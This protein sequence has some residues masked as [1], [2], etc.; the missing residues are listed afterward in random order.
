MRKK[1]LVAVILAIA[2]MASLIVPAQ[3][4]AG[5][6][7]SVPPMPNIT[8]Y[9][10][11]GW[12]AT[13]WRMET[14]LQ[15]G[16]VMYSYD[17]DPSRVN[18]GYSGYSDYQ[19]GIAPDA[20]Q[21]TSMPDQFKGAD[22]FITRPTGLNK[23]YFH[24]EQA[25]TVYAAI[26]DSYTTNPS[27]F[28]GWNN[29]NY[30]MKIK[31]GTTYHVVSKNFNG[32]QDINLGTG[33]QDGGKKNVF[34]VILPQNGQTVYNATQTGNPL[35]AEGTKPA[36][37]AADEAYQYYLNDV[38][39]LYSGTAVPAGYEGKN[40]SLTTGTAGTKTIAD[41]QNMA[42]NMTFIP[43]DTS[44][45]GSV[46]DGSDQT[47][48][49][50][51]RGYSTSPTLATPNIMTID[52]GGQAK[53][54]KIVLKCMNKSSWADRTQNIKLEYS[55]DGV[56]YKTLVAAKDYVFTMTK[57]NV[58]DPI[59]FNQVTARFVRATI[60]TNT[61]Q[62]AGQIAE[63]EIYGPAQTYELE[64]KLID[65]G[66]TVTEHYI[67]VTKADKF[68]YETAEFTKSFSQDISGKVIFEGKVMSSETNQYMEIPVMTDA[69]GKEAV[70]L[71]FDED[72]LMKAASAD[73]VKEIAP[74]TANTWYT[75]K[76]LVD[77]DADE[78]E[79]WVD[80]IRKAQ[81]ISFV[82]NI[83]S[84]AKLRFAVGIEAEGTLYVDNLRLY[85]N[86]EIYVVQDEF[87]EANTGSTYTTGWSYTGSATIANVPFATDKSIYMNGTGNTA[88]RSF[89]PISGDVTVE[90]KVKP[91]TENWVTMPMVTD[92]S[93]KVAAKVAFYQNSLYISNGDN[94]VYVCDQEIPNNYYLA[95]NWFTIKLIM[96]TYTNR[97]DF[98]VDGAPR[99]SGASFVE[100]V[101]SVSRVVFKNEQNSQMYIDNVTVYDSASLARG[102]Y[103]Q[104]NVFNVRDFGAKGDGVT[105]DTAAVDAAILAAAGTG[106]TVLFENGT[107]YVGQI[108]PLS[109]MTIF[110][111][112]S[113]TLFFKMDRK[114]Y[115]HITASRGY[116]GNNQIAC[117]LFLT[118]DGTHN[119]RIDGGGIIDGNGFYGYDQ[120]DPK[121]ASSTQRPC[122]MYLTLSHDLF[123]QNLSLINAP[124][125]TV[126]PY[127]STNLTFRNVSITNH[128]APN[129]D[130][131]DPTN[132]S[133]MTVENCYIIAG[134]DAFC[135]KSGNDVPSY[136][137][138][139]RNCFLQSYCN[140]IKFG[141]DSYDAF[142]NY[143]FE[144]IWM[145]NVGMSGI[146]LQ[147]VDGSE[148]QNISF[149][150]I[151]MIDVTS[152]INLMVG[153]RCRTYSGGGNAA[154][155][156]GFVRDIYFEDISFQNP[157]HS[158]FGHK[159]NKE[160]PEILIYGLSE[161]KI[162]N[163]NGLPDA[164][165][166][167]DHSVS[168]VYFKNV[169]F[170]GVGGMTSTPNF[171]DGIGSGYPEYDGLGESVGYAGSV[172]WANNV[173]FEN[174]TYTLENNNDAR[175][176]AIAYASEYS[177]NAYHEPLKAMQVIGVPT[178]TVDIG[179]DAS[180]LGLPSTVRVV[181]EDNSIVDVA[182]AS[183][184]TSAYNKNKEGAY[185]VTATL[186]A[187]NDV[188]DANA[189][190]LSTT[191]YVESSVLR[192][193]VNKDEKVDTADMLKIRDL[194]LSETWVYEDLKI[195]DLN[196]NGKLDVADILLVRAIIMAQ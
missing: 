162:N 51:P 50:G 175:T 13:W 81:N 171:D 137:V 189:L 23:I 196:G 70:K 35:V 20:F 48:W 88:I 43:N 117:G 27:S 29:T 60:Y 86:P 161:D 5:V 16:D 188:I 184:N 108:I 38:F 8:K 76:I 90:V 41:G 87:N 63:F 174:C 32:N 122:T 39:N 24:A 136:N 99:Y 21:I 75:L 78:Y 186:A 102:L 42:L 156:L 164:E 9:T 141:T 123:V 110:I 7:N 74:Y 62:D 121:P 49:Q 134:D 54:N 11:D 34:Y 107:F 127:E 132:C 105:D 10:T 124:H 146:T 118:E 55:T 150:R 100:D 67:A 19:N 180:A 153:N 15:L 190:T 192:G 170:E 44:Y 95:E 101:D 168:N 129:R 83:S 144:D 66:V 140:G 40:A 46:N 130:G 45:T 165:K 25:I 26:P 119:V 154:K 94:W 151:D 159:D 116:N 30:T 77:T 143:N 58:L 98:Y 96:N 167:G 80:H 113:A 191:V 92:N 17:A 73:G 68:T 85:D 179:V 185:E 106:G 79:V 176:Q 187:S 158:P 89:D 18:E 37:N 3:A 166:T 1:R 2:T 128:I 57:N 6:I 178:K 109:D 182:V 103:P 33:G 145:K 155:R 36:K 131:I 111:D 183:W 120:N 157:M 104:E 115:K 69:S 84:I 14:G 193:D 72:G 195:A 82:N 61:Q 47:Y 160:R 91:M 142:K 163:T 59:T 112:A 152:S 147:A 177:G 93:G 139:V 138:D 28:N 12:K 172:R 125:W 64:G 169:F 52:L 173:N 194:I 114:Q 4:A 31:D 135:P 65:E 149:K 53:I 22:F 181:R 126:V 133:N 71:Y 56:N 97:Y 148:I